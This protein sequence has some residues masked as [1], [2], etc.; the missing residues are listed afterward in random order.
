MMYSI[1]QLRMVLILGLAAPP[2]S[3]PTP[4]PA[5]G[6]YVELRKEYDGAMKKY[7]EER[8]QA[9]LDVQK[10]LLDQTKAAENAL[11]IAK[12]D[13][14]TAAARKQLEALAEVAAIKIR[15][16]AMN[17]TEEF[18]ARF[19][20]F[21]EKNPQDGSAFDSVMLALQLSGGV[22]G[23]VVDPAIKN[24]QTYHLANPGIKKASGCWRALPSV[25]RSRAL[26][27]MSWP[28][29]PAVRYKR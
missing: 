26:L 27:G 14:E 28:E 8:D 16:R 2:L 6:P 22:I 23:K 4:I 12:S 3:L 7:Q 9:K 29:I 19:L 21:A 11:L 25:K 18:S 13:Q 1:A 20:E 17:P 24:L 15:R 5:N 10:E